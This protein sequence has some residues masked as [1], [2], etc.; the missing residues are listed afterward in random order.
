MGTILIK[1]DKR[2]SK[3]LAELAKRLGA[4]VID[5]KDEQF[6]DLMLGTLMDKVKAGKTVSKDSI[7]KKLRS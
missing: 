2:S 5:V 1:T 4:N 3:I 7:L 6:D